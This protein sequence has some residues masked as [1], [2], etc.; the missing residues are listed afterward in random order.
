VTSG[1]GGSDGAELGCEGVPTVPCN[2]SRVAG[3]GVLWFWVTSSMVL[4]I[5]L[6][7]GS[8]SFPVLML[9]YPSGG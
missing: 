4:C 9:F 3:S 1:V 7:G 6:C 2:P 5:S 8:L